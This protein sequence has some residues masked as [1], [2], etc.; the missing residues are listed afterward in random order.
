MYNTP[1][2]HRVYT[3][4]V[5]AGKP[6]NSE[7]NVYEYTR[8]KKCS[9]DIGNP[10]IA[11]DL[12]HQH[13]KKEV[14]KPSSLNYVIPT[15]SIQLQSSLVLTCM[16]ASEFTIPASRFLLVFNLS[17]IKIQLIEI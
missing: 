8:S 6:H 4:G 3:M 10:T 12:F 14:I 17:P 16:I 15:S 5:N 1:R 9:E 7:Q 2:I 13:H 11:R